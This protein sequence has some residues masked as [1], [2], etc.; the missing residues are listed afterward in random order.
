MLTDFLKGPRKNSIVQFI[1]KNMYG[2]D[3][4]GFVVILAI[5]L[6]NTVANTE[7]KAT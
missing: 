4:K 5:K 1:I 2:E 6:L 3:M 7:N